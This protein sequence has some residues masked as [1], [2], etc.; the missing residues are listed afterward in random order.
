MNYPI[1]YIVSP[2]LEAFSNSRRIYLTT[3]LRARLS[4]A[5][6]MAVISHE[7]GHIEREH[8]IEKAGLD[9]LAIIIGLALWWPGFDLFIG[10]RLVLLWAVAIA[11]YLGRRAVNHWCEY[12]ADAYAVKRGHGDDLAAAICIVTNEHRLATHEHPSVQDRVTRIYEK[13]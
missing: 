7:T 11:W 9:L 8:W 12:D 5:Q 4:G 6:L 2:A 13:T 3:G 10:V 1:Q